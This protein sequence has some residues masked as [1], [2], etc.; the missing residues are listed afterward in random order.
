MT[1]QGTM[2][3][4]HL[5]GA[6]AGGL[7]SGV[8]GG[9]TTWPTPTVPMPVRRIAARCTVRSR[10]VLLPGVYSRADDFIT[11]GFIDDLHRLVPGCEGLLADAHLGY[12]VEGDLLR[13]LREDVVRPAAPV[14][15]ASAGAPAAPRPWLVGVS[16][17]GFAALAYAMRHGAEIAGVLALAP[18]LGRRELLR[19]IS[20]AGGPQAWRARPA[21]D[22]P[23]EPH[24]QIENE[25]W[26]WLA[27]PG[28]GHAA[29]VPVYLGYGRDDR[30]AEA[31]RVLQSL[32]P[33]GHTEVVEGGHD[34][35]PWRALW[36]HWLQR[37][38]LPGT[39][40]ATPS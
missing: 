17:G 38:A 36:R 40:C 2:R 15:E 6:L 5:L 39:T 8:P 12:F 18:Y 14:A 35:P 34:W 27:R 7:L 32:L 20:A 26:R 11:E 22:E 25:L 10:C 9:C 31:Q 37:G 16:L 1:T 13:R 30:F 29:T 21:G 28:L 33:A 4:R 24:A 19:D 23:A 3:R